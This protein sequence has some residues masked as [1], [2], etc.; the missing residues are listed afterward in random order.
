VILDFVARLR[1]GLTRTRARIHDLLDEAV[2]RGVFDDRAAAEIEEALLAVDAGPEIAATLVEEIRA[3]IRDAGGGVTAATV[4]EALAMKI[5]RRLREVE[6]PPIKTAPP[7]VTLVIGVN[8]VGKTTTVAKL[9]AQTRATGRSVLLGA[10]DTFRAAAVEQLKV[11]GE[12]IGAPVVAQ[13]E[14]ADPAAVAFDAVQAGIARKVDEV[15]ID[16]A[17]RLHTKSNLMKELEKVGRVVR[18][19]RDPVEVLLV[20]DA[21]TGQNGILQ[22]ERFASAIPLTGLVITKL[23]GSA[24]AGVILE[25]VRRFRVPVRHIGVGEAVEDLLLFDAKAFAEELVA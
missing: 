13:A 8:G 20:L 5:E 21:T 15:L 18:K 12:R 17:G 1:N 14:G 19:L 7:R 25:A 10:A 24:R 4:R 22:V 9:A 11:W 3:W 23:D 16:T 6:T 2:G